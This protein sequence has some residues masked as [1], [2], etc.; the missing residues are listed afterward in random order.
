VLN[1]Y[2]YG[3]TLYLARRYDEAIVQLERTVEMDADFPG[4]YEYL[5]SLYRLK[6]DND[7]AF[8][9]FVRFLTQKRESAEQI[10][11]WKTI[12]AQ[13]GWRG[14]DER[15]LEKEKEDKKNGNPNFVYM[16]RLYTKLE[17]PEQAFAYLEKAF[18]AHLWGMVKLKVEPDFDPLR[19]DP[20]FDDLVR[21]V[22]LK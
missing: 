4:T 22:G 20:R 11:S 8:E 12:Y 7:R 5:S 19:S 18:G 1:F 9:W 14:V 17:M 13:T 15:Q 2:I 6:G 10:Q 21:R 16:A 3:R